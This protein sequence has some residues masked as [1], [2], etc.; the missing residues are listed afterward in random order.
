MND[1]NGK[2]SEKRNSNPII[3]KVDI[4]VLPYI[5]KLRYMTINIASVFVDYL[6]IAIR[7]KTNIF[8][9]QPY[10]FYEKGCIEYH[11]KIILQ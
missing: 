8:F 2:S 1:T 6:L 10:S 4:N 3:V 7:L 5:G 9:T 11:N